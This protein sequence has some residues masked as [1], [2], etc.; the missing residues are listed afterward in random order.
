MSRSS[1]PFVDSLARAKYIHKNTDLGGERIDKLEDVVSHLITCLEE[2][3]KN[4][5][6]LVV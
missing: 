1:N 6:K 4:A 5:G 2:I 3:Q